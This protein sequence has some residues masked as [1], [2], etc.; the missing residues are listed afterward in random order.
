MGKTALF[1]GSF[2]PIHLGHR[3]CIQHL[4]QK[5]TFARVI[6]IPTSRN[7]LKNHQQPALPKD[8]LKMIKL[9]LTDCSDAISID[10]SEIMR[11][12]PAYTFETLK[13][14]AK[15]YSPENLH[16]VMGLD[17]FQ[18]MDQ[19]RNLNEVLRMTNLLVISRPSCHTPLKYRDLPE[20][21][22]I[23]VQSF[24]K[25]FI[26]L[27]TGRSIDFQEVK[28]RDISSSLIRKKL[29][30]GQ[31]FDSFIDSKVAEYI[32]KNNVY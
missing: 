20:G 32:K 23:R 24:G 7:P 19:W 28:T 11:E 10:C 15:K 21:I 22:Q 29:E 9:A 16:F 1:G 18:T 13:H 14:H 6:L 12:K 30:T 2:D 8:R 25:G 5:M 3:D 27:D 26:L 31:S 4:T 17:T